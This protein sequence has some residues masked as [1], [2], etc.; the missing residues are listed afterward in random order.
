MTETNMKKVQISVIGIFV[1][2]F[3]LVIWLTNTN[4]FIKKDYLDFKKT[5]I[6]STLISKK[7]EHPTKANKIYLKN[8]TQLIVLREIFDRLEIGD[9][10]VKKTNS[11]SIIFKTKFGLLIDDYNVFKREKYLKSLN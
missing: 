8:G 6:N 7:D 2:I 10:I 3:C 11:D 4:Y 1:V 9:S 5:K